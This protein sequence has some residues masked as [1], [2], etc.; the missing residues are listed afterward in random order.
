MM[1]SK[2]VCAFCEP[3]GCMG[4][5]PD[6]KAKGRQLQGKIATEGF[7]VEHF[8]GKLLVGGTVSGE[9]L[10]GVQDVDLRF[11]VLCSLGPAG[12]QARMRRPSSAEARRSCMNCFRDATRCAASVAN[13]RQTT[14]THLKVAVNGAEYLINNRPLRS[15]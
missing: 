10:D 4:F 15:S 1:R 2:Q 11:K 5:V 12:I 14:H 8:A 9:H 6:D 3:S 13:L 7:R